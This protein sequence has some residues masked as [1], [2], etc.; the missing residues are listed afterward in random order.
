MGIWAEIWLGIWKE[1][2]LKIWLGD[3]W[4]N[5]GGKRTFATSAKWHLHSLLWSTHWLWSVPPWLWSYPLLWLSRKS[6]TL[7]SS[8]FTADNWKGSTLCLR[9]VNRCCDRGRFDWRSFWRFDWKGYCDFD[10]ECDWDNRRLEWWHTAT[11]TYL[12]TKWP[13]NKCNCGNRW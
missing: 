10:W 4:V 13:K 2:W 3:T 12:F 6:T 11:A 5:E 9:C 1:I 8:S 7:T